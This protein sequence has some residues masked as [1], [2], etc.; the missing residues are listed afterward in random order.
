MFHAFL[1]DLRI[2]V[3]F[4]VM[5]TNAIWIYTILVFKQ[6]KLHVLFKTITKYNLVCMTN[7]VGKFVWSS[8][9]VLWVYLSSYG[10]DMRFSLCCLILIFLQGVAICNK[11]IVFKLG[12]PTIYA[13]P[14]RSCHWFSWWI[15]F[16]DLTSKTYKCCIY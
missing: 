8:G 9:N 5:Y 13:T 2:T 14:S 1:S 16:Y 3:S 4:P 15:F 12:L 6:D 7:K 10:F 11:L